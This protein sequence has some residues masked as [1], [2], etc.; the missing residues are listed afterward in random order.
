MIKAATG[1]IATYMARTWNIQGNA[2]RENVAR[3]Y[4][5]EKGTIYLFI[6]AVRFTPFDRNSEQKIVVCPLLQAGLANR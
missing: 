4:R 1:M 6:R 3:L 2:S 5:Q